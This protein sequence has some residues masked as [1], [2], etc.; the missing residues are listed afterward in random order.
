MPV[1]LVSFTDER[2]PNGLRLII[3]ED[4]LA[5]VVA[6]NIWYDVG[7]KHEVTGQDRLRPPLRARD[8]PGLAERRQG[9]AHRPRPGGRRD[10]ERHDLAGPDE[11]LRDH[12]RPPGGARAVARGGPDGHPPRRAQPG[13]PRQ[14]ARGRQ[15]REALVVRQPALRLVE[16]EAPRAPLPAGASVPPHHD[17]LHG[18][19]QRGVARRRPGVLPDL[20]R[21][22]QC[23]AGRGRRCRAPPGAGVGAPLLR[24]DSGEP[25]LPDELR[26][27]SLPPTL[28]GERR[29][30]II[31]KVPLPRVYF[32]LPG[33]GLRRSQARRPRCRGADP[34]R[35]Q[36]EPAASPPGA[37]RADRPGR[38]ALHAGLHR[39][40][41]G[42]R[43]LGDR[44]SGRRRG[45]G[46]GSLRGGAR[47][48][49]QGTRHRRRAGTGQG[50]DR[51]RRA[52]RAPAGRGASRSAGDVRHAVRR[53]GSDQR[54]WPATWP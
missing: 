42:H 14:P 44:P 20:V 9:G 52:R 6:V 1:P 12:A 40:R 28:G 45:A 3:A 4:H 19:P 29:E 26:D 11:L 39:R 37:R 8:V 49:G 25:V 43:G 54:C 35:R 51:G 23:G 16:R 5:P 50:P 10:D 30:T 48:A 33:A 27:L 7:S 41:V 38:R 36:G 13:E 15:E 21:A 31:D 18:R 47:A 53:S 46:R 24:G 32:G 34:R 17:R 2:L 22:E